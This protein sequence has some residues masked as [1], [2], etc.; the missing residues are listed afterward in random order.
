ML[1]DMQAVMDGQSHA[2][3]DNMS[4]EQYRL[5][6]RRSILT[7]PAGR[8]PDTPEP[9]DDDIGNGIRTEVLGSARAIVQA[10][11]AVLHPNSVPVYEEERAIGIGWWS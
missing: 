6:I 8:A 2:P 10:F 3:A 5:L 7:L 4:A 11:D 1:A 9:F